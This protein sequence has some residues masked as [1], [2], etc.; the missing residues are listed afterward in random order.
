MTGPRSAGGPAPETVTLP[1]MTK[2]RIL[3]L[4]SAGTLLASGCTPIVA[5]R[6]NMVEPERLAR[7]EVGKSTRDQVQNILGTPT[8]TSTLDPNTWYY[9]GRRTEQV[10]FF[11]PEV[12]DQKILRVRFEF[13]GTVSEMQKIDGSEA[14]AIDPVERQTPTAGRELGFFEQL[15]GTI[16]RGRPSTDGPSGG[17]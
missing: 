1:I 4:L 5:T 11:A 15:F 10:A 2:T 16:G 13:D 9:I 12:V 8:A 3:L 17:R 7:L 6:G 14:R